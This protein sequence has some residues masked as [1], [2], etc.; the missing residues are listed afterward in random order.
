MARQDNKKRKD[1]IKDCSKF[2]IMHILEEYKHKLIQKKPQ[3]HHLARVVYSD[4]LLLKN[5]DDKWNCK[6]ITCDSVLPRDNQYMHP[7]HFRTAGSSLKYKFVDD[8]VRPQCM[9]CNVMLNGNYQIYTLKM[10]EKFW[11]ERVET[12][13]HDQEI[14]QIKNREYAEKIQGRYNILHRIK[15]LV[16]S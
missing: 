13:L 16:K 5:C 10:I 12:I 7:W 2:E 6:C 8:N 3:L 1:I 4:Y 15:T 11:K 14:I 9:R